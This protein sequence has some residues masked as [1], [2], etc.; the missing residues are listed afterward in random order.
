MLRNPGMTDLS[1]STTHFN[2]LIKFVTARNQRQGEI[3]GE[4]ISNNTMLCAA[5]RQNISIH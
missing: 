5:A 2:G 1:Q 4:A 3:T